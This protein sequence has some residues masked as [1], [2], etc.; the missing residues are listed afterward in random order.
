MSDNVSWCVVAAPSE[1][2]AKKVFPDSENAVEELWSAILK[3][4]RADQADPV[5]AWADHDHNL[6]SKAK[7]LTE[8]K[9]KTLHYTAPGT[10]LSIELPERHVWLGGGGRMQM[11]L[12]SSRICRQKKCSR[13]QKDRC[14]RTRLEH[15]TA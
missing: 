14:Q 13:Y 3:A 8:K 11:V 5:A 6:R 1:S 2:W 12:I 15:K 9:Y 10:E 7:F 4:T